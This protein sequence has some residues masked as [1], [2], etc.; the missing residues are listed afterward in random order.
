MERDLTHPV[1]NVYDTLKTARLNILYYEE[2]LKK[3]ERMLLGIQIILAA[4]VPSSAIS[5]FKIWDFGL[6]QYAWEILVAFSSFVAF[7]QPFLGLPKKVKTYSEL[8]DGYKVLYFDLVELKQKVEDDQAYSSPHKKLLKAA[9]D[10][11]K[12]LEVRETGIPLDKRLRKKCQEA[13]KLELPAKIFFIPK[14][15]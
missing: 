5:G 3:T 14:E 6:G 9:R 15:K 10:R 4:T 1:W 2:K 13:V 7:L 8:V 12:K 11:R